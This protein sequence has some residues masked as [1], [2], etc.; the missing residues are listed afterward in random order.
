MFHTIG[1]A[2]R[3]FG[4]DARDN[5][6]R[7]LYVY[8]K[9]QQK[10][11]E[12]YPDAPLLIASWD[13]L[14]WKNDDV[15]RL[16]DEFDPRRTIVLD[17][18]ADVADKGTLSR[19]GHARQVPLDLRHLPLL[20]PQQRHPRGLRAFSTP[21]LQRGGRPTRKCRGAGDVVGDFAQRHVPAGIPGRQ[22]LAAASDL[23][24]AQATP[25]Y[26]Q[27]RYPAELAAAMRP[28]WTSFLTLVAEPC[29]GARVDAND[30]W[31]SRSFAC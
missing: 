19:L 17:Y 22:Q 28:L 6:Q 18:T 26:C 31:R 11:R 9:T 3:T 16:L 12:H 27:T 23:E 21:R 30:V 5:L 8:R 29:T 24:L 4:K 10:L 7:K 14:W 15:R 13:F 20:C 25:R 1:M 2:E